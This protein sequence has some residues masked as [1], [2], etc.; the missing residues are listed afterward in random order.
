L[1]ENNV[2]PFDSVPVIPSLFAASAGSID[3]DKLDETRHAV[4]AIILG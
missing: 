3:V 2:G 4:I 1:T